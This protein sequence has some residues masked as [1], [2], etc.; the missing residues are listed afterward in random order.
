MKPITR[1]PNKRSVGPR[2]LRLP[3]RPLPRAYD[4]SVNR[5]TTTRLPTQ[6]SPQLDQIPD[7][8]T[9]QNSPKKFHTPAPRNL[10]SR[11]SQPPPTPWRSS[12]AHELPPL[13]SRL[14]LFAALLVG[15]RGSAHGRGGGGA[16]AGGGGGGARG[17][18]AQGL[19]RPRQGGDR[20]GR[21]RRGV[22][23][24]RRRHRALPQRDAGHARGQGRAHPR[25]HLLQVLPR[26][27]PG[28]RRG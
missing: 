27:L 13:A 12:P 20:Q 26:S 9:H 3:C 18:E 21:A 11:C 19:L 8:K 14:L 1:R 28:P 4:F 22:G 16:V 17:G 24:P 10:E 7:E 2:I 23:A 5:A 15:G 25:R 6:T